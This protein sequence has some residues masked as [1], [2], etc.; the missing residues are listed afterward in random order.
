MTK[1]ECLS[2]F[3]LQVEAIVFLCLSKHFLS[4]QEK[5]CTNSL[6]SKSF[7]LWVGDLNCFMCNNKKCSPIFNQLRTKNLIVLDIRLQS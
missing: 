7:P 6:F 5:W 3:S 1:Y 4:V 2:I